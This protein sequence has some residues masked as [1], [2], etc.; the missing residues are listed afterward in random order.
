MWLHYIKMEFQNIA[1][2]LET[3]SD[4]EDLPRNVP[5]N[6]LKSMINQE[7]ITMLIKKLESKH[8]C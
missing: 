1:N 7:E 8:Q 6:G 5:K 2:F 4:D 3:T